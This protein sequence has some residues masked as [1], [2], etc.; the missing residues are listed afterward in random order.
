MKPQTSV[1]LPASKV[2]SEA[3]CSEFPALVPI[4]QAL[5]TWCG[6]EA[7]DVRKSN[8]WK[9]TGRDWAKREAKTECIKFDL[10]D[11]LPV[12]AYMPGE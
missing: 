1:V 9:G 5:L 3:C 12:I 2:M 4:S 8:S 11:S 10:E 7:V 6:R